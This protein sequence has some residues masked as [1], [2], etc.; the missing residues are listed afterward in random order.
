MA[1]IPFPLQP[2]LSYREDRVDQLSRELALLEAE[3]LARQEALSAL[4][5]EREATLSNQRKDEQARVDVSYLQRLAGHL[6]HLR[7]GVRCQSSAIAE[8]SE[9]IDAK[10][11]ELVEAMEQK[12]ILAKLKERRRKSFIAEWERQE[13]R[14]HDEIAI[15]RYVRRQRDKGVA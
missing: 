8:L 9:R 1:E 7:E 3:R 13:A 2:V 4:L 12:E 5:A 11:Q 10:R 6:A 14:Y 15:I